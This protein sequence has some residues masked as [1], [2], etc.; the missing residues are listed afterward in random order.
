VLPFEDLSA[1]GTNRPFTDGLHD[2]L[3]T[4]LSKVA[5]LRVTSRTSV[6]E[7]RE[8]HKSIPQVAAELGVSAVLEGA[9]QRSGDRLR[10]NVQLI[11]G[12]SDAHLWAETY[13]S[14]LT[15]AD[16]FD[17]QTRIATAITTALRAQL[18]REEQAEIAAQPTQD[19]AAYEAYLAGLAEGYW[20]VSDT[21]AVLFET[22]AERDPGFADAW[23]A[24]AIARA[25]QARVLSESPGETE[26]LARERRA[27]ER[28]LQRARDLAPRTRAT[29]LAEGYVRYYVEW[30]FAAAARSFEA[31]AAQ[32]PQDATVVASTGLIHRRLGNWAE[33]LER[34]RAAVALEPN[35]ATLIMDLA[36]N[37]AYLHRLDE[38]ERTIRPGLARHPDDP[39]VRARRVRDHSP[40]VA[41]GATS[42]SRCGHGRPPRTSAPSSTSAS[43]SGPTAWRPITGGSAPSP[44]VSG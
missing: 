44:R 28:A 30:D 19:L 2:D 29:L 39:W 18:T 1:D 6:Q 38:A 7:Y 3:L 37:Y 42:S 10:L 5:A 27:A 20:S 23:A 11:D 25:W 21:A 13:D 33:A 14:D 43:S 35:S 26:A 31:L 15:V 4:Q 24:A 36:R 12:E 8:T 41:P 40:C 9:L 34:S 22:A 16:I 32:Y 17:I